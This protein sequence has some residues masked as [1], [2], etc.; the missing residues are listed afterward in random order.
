MRSIPLGLA[1]LAACG[2]GTETP[3]QY[4]FGGDRPT[5][6]KVPAGYDHSVPTPLLVVLH[7]FGANGYTQLAYTGLEDLV[8]DEGILL[9][10]PDGTVNSEG[11]Q[12]WNATDACCDDEGSGVDD[13]A[14]IG[15]L[16]EE[17]SS[18]WNVDPGRVFFFGH[19]NGGYMSYRM[20]CD[21]ADLVAA[22]F[23]LAGATWA[24]PTAC[25]PS[26]P[27]SVLQLHGDA[28]STVLYQGGDF[29][30]GS[31]PGAAVTV[32]TWADYNG[33]TGALTDDP[34]RLDI[35]RSI[36]GD[37]TRTAHHAGCPAGIDAELWT[38]EGG[39][40]IPNLAPTAFPGIVW[41]WL[42]AHP[43]AAQ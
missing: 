42:S 7:G 25:A 27:V 16:V 17:I 8:D 36:T 41:S 19:S 11:R 14:Y 34:A 32:A 1:L 35:D 43:R 30:I 13:V 4:V 15:G 5:Y 37:D 33:C 29:S 40:H 3:D 21:R 18:V 20:A 12:F 10:A 23:S 6:L 26:Q 39:G 24:D 2:G 28:D 38:I 9:I 31:Y 22:L